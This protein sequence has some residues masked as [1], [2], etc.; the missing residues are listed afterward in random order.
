MSPG[1]RALW[2]RLCL[3]VVRWLVMEVVESLDA[4]GSVEP[5][6]MVSFV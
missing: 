5:D 3:I 1:V 6:E 2:W 4:E